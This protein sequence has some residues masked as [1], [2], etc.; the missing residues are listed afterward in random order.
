MRKLIVTA[1]ALVMATATTSFAQ[2]CC[3]GTAAPMQIMS[4][5]AME[6][7]PVP[8]QQMTYEQAP[9]GD[10]GCCPKAC[11]PAPAPVACCPTPAPAPAP[12][13]APA[14]Q[15]VSC[16]AKPA[17]TCCPA[18]QPVSCCQDACCQP[19][20]KCIL[21]KLWDLEKRKNAWLKRTFLH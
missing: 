21:A 3:G 5:P 8:M 10:Q 20:K 13:C 2:E 19:K 7:S 15:P 6:L 4:A 9:I 12:C 1:V 17:P 14:P 11:N 18:P 16:C